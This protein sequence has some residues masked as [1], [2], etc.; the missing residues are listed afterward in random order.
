MP[1]LASFGPASLKEGSKMEVRKGLLWLSIAVFLLLS[2]LI[3][4][5]SAPLAQGTA[6]PVVPY[7][8]WADK[9]HSA[10][11]IAYGIALD[12][13]GNAVV[14]GTAGII[15]Y[16]AG[17][18]LLWHAQYPGAA[19]GVAID[20][21]DDIIV[22]GKGGL[23]KLS[24]D[25]RRLWRVEGE[26]VDV[27]VARGDWIIAAGPKGVEVYDPSGRKLKQLHYDG[28]PVAVAASGEMVA[29]VGTGGLAG[30]ELTSSEV[31]W[32]A[33]FP[34]A[35]KDVAIDSEGNIIVVG[36]TER[37]GHIAKYGQGGAWEWSELPRG[38]PQAVAT[39]PADPFSTEP[40]DQIIITGSVFQGGDFDY[41]TAKFT[42]EGNQ[43]WEIRYDGGFGDDIAFDIAISREGYIYVTGVSTLPEG[44]SEGIHSPH[45]QD[46]YTVQYAERLLP[47]VLAG[48]DDCPTGSTPPVA[49]FELLAGAPL[50][51][52]PISLANRSFDPD[53][54][55]ITWGWDFGDGT[56][57]QEWEPLHSYA[58][59]GAYT[60]ELVVVDN[61]YCTAK[62][63]GQIEVANR[64]PE[65]SFSWEA[66]EAA[67]LVADFSWSVS[68]EVFGKY[69]QGFA[70]EGPT[71]LDEILFDD[72]SSSGAGEIVVHFRGEALDPEGR[73]VTWHWDFG[74]GTTL[75]C[76]EPNPTHSYAQ[77]GSY[78]VTLTVTDMDGGK[79][80]YEEVVT[81][82]GAAGE[83]ISWEWDFGDGSSSTVENP[84]HHYLDD[85]IYRVT[86]TVRD[87]F[88]N[89]AHAQKTIEILN[90]PPVADFTWSF[91]GLSG[92]WAMPTCAD[93]G[94]P[95]SEDGFFGTACG[96]PTPP[97]DAG[98][99]EFI[100]LSDDSEPWLDAKVQEWTFSNGF[101]FCTLMPDCMID[102]EPQVLLFTDETMTFLYRGPID[103]TL[104]V[105]DD[106]YASDSTVKTIGIAN[107]PPYALFDWEVAAGGI[108]ALAS[109]SAPGSTEAPRLYQFGGFT[110]TACDSCE[111]LYGTGDPVVST[112]STDGA[113]TV[114]RTVYSECDVWD[115]GQRAICG[116]GGTFYVEV[117]IEGTEIPTVM[118]S[119]SA[120]AGWEIL[121]C[122]DPSGALSCDPD[123]IG[124][125]IN[126]GGSFTF[127]YEVSPPWWTG[128]VTF[129]GN[130]ISGTYASGHRIVSLDSTVI[131]CDRVNTEVYSYFY[132]YNAEDAQWVFG[133]PGIDLNGD[134]ILSYDWDFG[135]WG[136]ASG[137][138]PLGGYC[139]GS[140]PGE[141]IFPLSDL[142]C[143]FDGFDWVW[144]YEPLEVTL[145][146]TDEG[147]GSTNAS[148]TIP[149]GG[150]CM[151]WA[152]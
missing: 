99:I 142:Q 30:Y 56:I 74:D 136:T 135:S 145:T 95:Y 103:V 134:D 49:E 7:V 58:R 141:C 138:E 113:L 126:V 108:V 83:I 38:E 47:E 11:D 57:S 17:G 35:P 85:G 42:S 96:E 36:I 16:S 130:T 28:Q 127:G 40:G 8:N 44:A 106:D 6:A 22:A 5:P 72:L 140:W 55:L 146:V 18:M 79:A 19:L 81:I 20:L 3:S 80:T 120:P 21:L 50:T 102:W 125:F 100:N 112:S 62:A 12:L 131:A 98:I 52:D 53:G 66:E 69:P 124:G 137:K 148:V 59:P 151:G 24:P 73:V 71:A 93:L 27:A 45:G 32:Q 9:F 97:Q 37:G 82:E 139:G 107:I 64:P 110:E 122:D 75:C 101:A 76:D 109:E 150:S 77:P 87:E 132:G 117:T 39:W 118:V 43:L 116:I 115:G 41:L 144:S 70:P 133:L 88:G 152:E 111:A 91:L 121:W 34:G 65:V 68:R 119:E 25:G 46:Y 29:V 149:L 63:M 61:D 67:E 92:E 15:K 23:S 2:L 86:L 33:Q 147:G 84:T 90:V 48:E 4:M 104:E 143:I 105:L 128:S 78:F 1:L 60:V 26:F 89:T 114:T 13:G 54:Y 10:E 51:G 31:S 129:G 123:S 14:V 94:L